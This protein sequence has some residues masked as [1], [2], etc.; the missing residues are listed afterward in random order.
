MEADPWASG[1]LWAVPALCLS[2]AALIGVTVTAFMSGYGAVAMP[3]TTISR[4][5]NPVDEAEVR[6]SVRAVQHALRTLHQRS[7][8]LAAL[9]Q[10]LAVRRER[11]AAHAGAGGFGRSWFAAAMQVVP[12]RLRSNSYRWA[13]QRRVSCARETSALVH[14]LRSRCARLDELLREKERAAFATTV[15]GRVMNRCGWFF[16]AYCGY[17]FVSAATSIL[18]LRTPGV[19]PVTKGMIVVRLLRGGDVPAAIRALVRPPLDLHDGAW[20]AEAFWS[21]SI[22]LVLVGAMIFSS[23]RGFL[24]QASRSMSSLTS[25]IQGRR[26]VS[27]ISHLYEEDDLLVY[28][29]AH[30][31]GF[32]FLSVVLL[33]RASL[34]AAYRRG[35]SEAG[36]GGLEWR[37]YHSWFDLLF[38]AAASATLAIFAFSRYKHGTP[39]ASPPRRLG[40]RNPTSFADCAAS[41]QALPDARPV[42]RAPGGLSPPGIEKGTP[43]ALSPPP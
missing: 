4:L 24:T 39:P 9:Q 10:Q 22:S 13:R 1:V 19:D 15:R 34:P 11:D 7:S 20:E 16:A 41:S 6:E 3:W 32:Y 42:R 23:V 25:H 31:Q 43:T 12:L 33:V 14:A 38:L 29:I 8:Q 17:K 30:V 5:L 35:L 37:F 2:R 26:S 21:E 27:H 36:F 40:G 18:L 28:V